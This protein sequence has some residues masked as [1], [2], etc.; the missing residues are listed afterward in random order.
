MTPTGLDAA[1]TTAV[2]TAWPTASTALGPLATTATGGSPTLVLLVFAA[3]FAATLLSLYL[4]TRLY[5]GYRAGGG[6]GMLGLF[7]GLVLL[8]T[9]PILLRLVLTN[10]GGVPATTRALAATTS[11]LLG[12]LVVLGVVYDRG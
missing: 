5:R 11:Q 9:V 7:V 1:W 10:V 8:T 2:A 4:A 6:R 3:L 12:L